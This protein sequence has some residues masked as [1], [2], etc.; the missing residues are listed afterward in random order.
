MDLEGKP[1]F[2]QQNLIN[3]EAVLRRAADAN[4]ALDGLGRALVR[5]SRAANRPLRIGILGEANSGKSS[6]A[7]LLGGVSTV[8]GH[9]VENTR[10]PTL[11]KYAPEPFVAAFFE[12]GER[13]T[14]SASDNI[15]QTLAAIYESR[16]K[17]A[18]P[19]S[20][21]VPQGGIKWLEAGL[22]SD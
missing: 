16:E 19:S 18:L 22:P 3:G 6:L 21:R 4:P 1:G 10:L 12:S 11:L 2:S 17:V 8:P 7:N 20:T 9:P 5:I 14:L 13:I 15:P